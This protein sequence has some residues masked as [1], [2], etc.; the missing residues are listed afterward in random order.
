MKVAGTDTQKILVY[1]LIRQ[2]II[3]KLWNMEINVYFILFF[4]I[5]WFM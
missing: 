5:T 3:Q 4:I 1:F 2:Y